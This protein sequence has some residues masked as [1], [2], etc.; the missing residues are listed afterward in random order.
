[1][2]PYFRL[3]YF[4]CVGNAAGFEKFIETLRV[5]IAVRP[6][7]LAFGFF[8]NEGVFLRSSFIFVIGPDLTV[9]IVYMDASR[10]KLD[11]Q[12]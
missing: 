5:L 2:S 4:F 11:R 8:R 1:M 6:N 12:G 10:D 7:C 9:W 3:Y